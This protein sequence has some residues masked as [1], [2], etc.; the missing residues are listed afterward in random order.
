VIAAIDE[1]ISSLSKK[2]NQFNL[3]VQ[4]TGLNITQT[5]PGTGM[6]VNV[7]GGGSG[8]Q[9]TGL[10]ISAGGGEIQVAQAAADQALREQAE[11][12]VQILTELKTALMQPKPNRDTISSKLSELAGTYIP[13]IAKAIIEKLIQSRLGL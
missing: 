7:Q 2:P 4:T 5:A 1:A 11:K 6:Q 8:S 3:V 13:D 12:A 10:N 9:T